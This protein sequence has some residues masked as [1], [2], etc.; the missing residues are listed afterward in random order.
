M[1]TLSGSLRL[2]PTRIG[3]LVDPTDVGSLR[4]VF[5]VCTCLWGGSF[6][7]IIPVCGTIPDAWSDPPFPMPS[8]MELAAGY[9]DFFEPDVF[10]ETRPG[11]AEQ[12]GLARTDLDFGQPR[13]IPLEA[14][15][16][17]AGTHAFSV[18]FGTDTFSIYKSMYDREYKFVARHSHRVAL[19]EAD[20]DASPF[21]EAAFGGFPTEG[22]LQALAGIYADAYDPV[23]LA[24]N[25]ANWVKVVK[26]EFRLPLSFTGETLEPDYNGWH[27]PTLFVA[28]PSN[29]LDLIDLWN[30]RQFHAQVLPMSLAWFQGAKDYLAV[31]IQANHRPLLGNPNGVMTTL[32]VQF[33]RSIVGSDHQ[34]A[35]ERGSAILSEAGLQ[36]LPN[37]PLTMKLWYDRIWKGGDDDL[38]RMTQRAEVSA[39][40]TDLELTLSDEG[41]DPS[42]RFTALSPTFGD[43]P[44]VDGAARWVNVLKFRSHGT[45]DTLALTLPSSFSHDT[46]RRFRLSETTLISREGF[47]LPQKYARQSEYFRFMTGREAIA[48]WLEHRG[49]TAQPSDPG[50]IA[51]QV[52]ASLNGFWGAGL[53]ADRDT[54]K[55]LDKMAKSVRRHA[56]GTTEEFPDRS[57]DVKQWKDLVNR[58]ANAR[59]GYRAGL[60][61]FID[62]NVLRLGLVLPCPSCQKK[63]W[64]GI[65]N[66]RL[67]LTCERCLKTF[68]FPQG[69]LNFQQTPWQ[70]RVVGPYSVPNYAGG[71]YSTVLALSVFARRLGGDNPKLTYTTGVELRTGDD[72][73][74]EV[75]FAFWY[76][77]ARMFGRE[78]EPALVFGEAKSFAAESFKDEDIARMRKLAELLPGTFIVFATLKDELST[79]ERAAIAALAMWGR[80]QLPNGSFRA[81]VIILTA[82]E[83][84]CSW[85]VD[86]TWKELGGKWAGFADSWCHNLDNLRTL[87]DV[88]QQLYLELPDPHARFDWTA[89]AAPGGAGQMAG[90]Y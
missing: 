36:G 7:P 16:I 20:P 71:A 5:Q 61:R 21:I 13:I 12:V 55:L 10:V 1:T 18:P 6:N 78:E 50:R 29:P 74:M 68:A 90:S 15:F 51:E 88:T 2:R 11:L 31:L 70:Y 82:T 24:P 19:F 41:S 44:G 4:R 22:P 89:P 73:R 79:A 26:E 43:R 33:G 47:I 38:G 8:P 63:N 56:D 17:L 58:R 86:H 57:I 40:K 69:S 45:D 48:D 32:E 64:F 87:A 84:F 28:D 23:R 9:L 34:K 52:L 75:D 72:T 25:A 39:A 37:A 62:S 60:D 46:A 42:C 14:Y 76:Q 77:R 30:L 66:L 35:V 53:L 54:L 80:E 59:W 49:I 27:M 3:F 67:K 85:R 65:D 81:P 83:L